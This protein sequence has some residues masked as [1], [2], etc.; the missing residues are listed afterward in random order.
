M[1]PTRRG[2]SL[3]VAVALAIAACGDDVTGPQNPEDVTF[4]AALG[5]N[6]SAMT[7]LP[8]GVY[9]QTVTEGTGGQLI[10]N[11]LF[12]ADYKGWF[13]NGTL[14][15]SGRLEGFRLSEMIPGFTG[16]AI[17]MRTGEVRKIVAPSVLGYGGNPPRDSGIPP[18]AV[19]VFEVTLIQISP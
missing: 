15:D 1:K 11:N 8:S 14:F 6:L 17:G 16:G 13:S 4:A 5:I 3:S 19:L 18:N 9:I 7:K 2:V 12:V 10:A